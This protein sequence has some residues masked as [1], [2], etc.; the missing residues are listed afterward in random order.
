MTL[1]EFDP[2]LAALALLGT[3]ITFV[4]AER[5]HAF[6]PVPWTNP[7]GLTVAAW[8][9]GV[10]V[11]GLTLSDYQAGTQPLVWILRP[12]VVALGWVMYR[13]RRA[14]GRWAVP[15][16]GGV[17]LGTAV[18]LVVTPLL[19]R[20][21]GAG[22]ELQAALALK[23]VTSAVG[24]DLAGRVGADAALTVPLII[25]TG[26][27][28]AAFGPLL[29]RRGLGSGT[30]AVGIAVGT[31]SHGIGTAAVAAEGRALPTALAGLA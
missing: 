15:L 18:S 7:V 28:G 5:L 31:A 27:L 19:A 1:P 9:A 14:L 29:L 10:A 23:S 21:L 17:V 25:V 12:A 11:T 3:I 13:Q 6:W 16:L 22:P 24:V 26:I 8:V 30:E 2:W 4:L 20:W